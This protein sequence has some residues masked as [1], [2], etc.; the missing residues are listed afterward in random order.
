[1][2]RRERF[3]VFAADDLNEPG[4]ITAGQTTITLTDASEFPTEGDFRILIDS[5]IMLVTAVSGNDFTVTRGVDGSTA[6]THNDAATVTGILT[7]GAMEAYIDHAT[8]VL[9]PSGKKAY[10]GRIEDINGNPMDV[11][12]F[13]WLNQ[14][15]ATAIDHNGGI[16][17]TMPNEANHNIRGKYITAPSTPYRLDALVQFNCGA[18]ES[19]SSGTYM[20]LFLRES[21]T[22]EL[23][24][25][26]ARFAHVWAMWHFTDETTFSA[27]IDSAVEMNDTCAWLA[28]ED[29]GTDI[30]GYASRDGINYQK[31][32]TDGRTAKLAGGA[33]QVGF[34]CNSA[35]CATG[36]PFHF[37]A[38]RFS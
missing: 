27:G 14:G 11:S 38:L 5:E 2:V 28:I 9:T 10:I 33:N 3:S 22:S 13:T 8:G 30:N 6:T 35:L 19:G 32:W 1:M 29:D 12:D 25:M 23:I 24:I 18:T 37:H 7:G 15:S 4:N 31:F 36:T 26:A 21:S 16:L 34:F 17:M 20:G